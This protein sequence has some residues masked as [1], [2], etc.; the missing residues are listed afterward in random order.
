MSAML[1]KYNVWG[2]FNMIIAKM[3]TNLT[4]LR[5]Q[6]ITE[7]IWLRYATYKS[8]FAGLQIR[9]ERYATLP[10]IGLKFMVFRNPRRLMLCSHQRN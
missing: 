6:R 9:S 10:W 4:F 2:G 7:R 8:C 5:Q 3:I 1:K